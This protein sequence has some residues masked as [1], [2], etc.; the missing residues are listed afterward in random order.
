MMG[1]YEF[2]RMCEEEGLSAS[3]AMHEWEV[4]QSERTEAFYEDYY[5]DPIVNIGWA[6]QDVIDMYRRER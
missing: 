4:Y 2:F 6:Q 5:N 3:E 1:M